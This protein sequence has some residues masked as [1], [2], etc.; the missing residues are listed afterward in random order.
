MISID[1]VGKQYIYNGLRLRNGHDSW[2]AVTQVFS[3]T[4]VWQKSLLSEDH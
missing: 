2:T 4:S 1:Y 3:I